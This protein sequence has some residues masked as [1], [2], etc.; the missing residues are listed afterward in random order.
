LSGSSITAYGHPGSG[1][2]YVSDLFYSP[3]LDM[4]ISV[5][6]NSH[7]DARS[8]AEAEGKITHSTLNDIARQ[9]FQTYSDLADS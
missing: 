3:E 6:V 2:G 9:I 7:S 1:G 5:L 8:R 4:S